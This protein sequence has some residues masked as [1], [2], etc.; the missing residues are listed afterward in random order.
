M[1]SSM[2]A[3]FLVIDIETIV[4]PTLPMPAKAEGSSL[5]PAPFHQI[6]AIGALWMS[7]EYRPI[8]LGVVGPRKTE[9]EVLE[10]FVR[11]V[12]E[13]RPDLVTYNG[14]G[15]DPPV[16]V[17]RCLRH[18]IAC[19][20]YY[21]PSGMRYRYSAQGHLDLMDYLTDHGA[22]R[23]VP[24]DT[25]TKLIGLPGKVGVDGK[26]VGPLIHAGMLEQVHAYCLCDVV[27]TA[28]LF[29]RVQLL[30]GLLDRDQYRAAMEVLLQWMR[31]D[32]RLRAVYD[33]VNQDL[34]LLR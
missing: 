1:L 2:P 19:R 14:R 29:L 33:G 20:P 5:P 34:L 9:P 6:V 24:L 13:R 25:L 7:D 3:S 22:S 4:D 21:Q 10:D 31:D 23:P 15:F 28:G 17:A 18:A 30:R 16:I 26:D 32:E 8:K 12:E 27:Q 11:F